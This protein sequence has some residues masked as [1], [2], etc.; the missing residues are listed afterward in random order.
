M[1]KILR[2]NMT[3]LTAKFEDVPEK[4]RLVGGRGL[5]SA[6]TCDEVPPTCHPLGPNNKV[7]FATGIVTGTSAP[8]SGRISVGG[9]SPLT[10]TIKES[11][12][13]GVA[14]QKLARLG[15]KA[16]IVEG[17]PKEKGKFW[18]LKVDKDGT[19]L[20]PADK[21][22]GKGLQ[23]TFP[24]LFDKFGKNV[25]IIG[26]GTSGERLM[27]SAGIC[28][29]DPENRPSR[30]AGRGGLGAVMG[31]KGLKAIILDD[32]G[33]PGV[34]IANKEVFESGRRKLIAALREHDITKPGGALNTTGTATL[35]SV[36]NEAGALPTRNFREGRFDGVN[37]IS[38][39]T[40]KETCEK[41]GGVGMVGHGCS[42]GCIIKCSN[43]YPNPDGTELVSVQEYE[44]VWSFGANC[45]I[46]DLDVTG[47]LI[48]LC[49]D[50][51]VDTIEAGVTIGVA[52]EAGLAKFGDGKK[53][54]ELMHE[55]G[56]G[57][58]LGRILG[59]GAV[60]TANAFGVVRCPTVKGQAMPAYD[61]RAIKGIGIIY[62]TSTMGADHTAG[63]TIAPEILGVSDD[64][65][66]FI[67]KK[68]DLARNFQHTTAYI[69]DSSGHCLFISFAVLDIPS[70]LEGVVEECNGVLGT[71]WTV[72]DM[73]R[74]G[75]EIVDRERAFNEAA[76]FTKV[77]DRLP[78]FMKYEK[79]PPHNV[80]FDVPDEEL[81][82]VHVS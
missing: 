16:I 9:K 24:F 52:M 21:F 82:K 50:Y 25:G 48:R 63:Y 61:P 2:V 59:S 32:K 10:G 58:P 77:D 49:N 60:A 40:I 8:T 5:T 81:D 56:K 44:S 15:I 22:V 17:Q 11:N 43:V 23:E 20:L 26:I 62:A 51:G 41:R 69:F 38:G 18:L 33:G 28:V 70:G 7:T 53:A 68:A 14:P 57:T 78:E 66:K 73:I 55:I 79:L 75:K 37:K 27:A 46:D 47:E 1:S 45:G 80:V 31:S 42:P 29:N 36:I 6:I 4:Y 3:D 19:Q 54:I 64:I 72:N 65:D 35:I 13:G 67:V 12:S 34:P 71:N 30:Y 39:E 74:M 76:G